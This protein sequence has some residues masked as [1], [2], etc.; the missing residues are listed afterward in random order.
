M[1]IHSAAHNGSIPG[2]AMYNKA[3]PCSIWWALRKPLRNVVIESGG[4]Y[5]KMLW[6]QSMFFPVA[7]VSFWKLDLLAKNKCCLAD[8]H[9]FS[10]SLWKRNVFKS[11]LTKAFDSFPSYLLFLFALFIGSISCLSEQTLLFNG[12]C[13]RTCFHWITQCSS[14][15]VFISICL[16]VCR[17]TQQ[18]QPT[19]PNLLS[20][21]SACEL[22]KASKSANICGSF[23]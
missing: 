5:W 15:P 7:Q 2:C 12:T 20:H 18:R 22:S 8:L 6:L 4:V 19:H 23:L 17:L 3:W 13:R 14:L 16:N 11:Y 10:A 21:R 9:L 1:R